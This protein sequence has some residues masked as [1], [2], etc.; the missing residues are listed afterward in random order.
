MV[1]TRVGECAKLLDDGRAGILV[2]PGAAD[3]LS[4]GLLLL[5]RSPERRA[6][7]GEALYQHVKYNYNAMNA[8]DQICRVYDSVLQ[9]NQ[10]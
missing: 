7:L 2:S 8:I 1:A 10:K 5:L 3:Q 4:K 9:V 6:V